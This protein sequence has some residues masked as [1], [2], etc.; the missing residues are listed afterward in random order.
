[1]C[2]VFRYNLCAVCLSAA[3]VLC[4][5]STACV[6]S[7]LSTACVLCVCCVLTV[8]FGTVFGTLFNRSSC[9]SLLVLCDIVSA[10]GTKLPELIRSPCQARLSKRSM[11]SLFVGFCVVC[12]HVYFIYY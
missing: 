11:I 4:G 3:L 1:M 6:L 8:A 9:V 12:L 5:L 10:F 7:D 2:W